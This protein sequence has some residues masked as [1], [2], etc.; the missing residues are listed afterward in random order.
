MISISLARVF[1]IFLGVF[2]ICT[3]ANTSAMDEGDPWR[4]TFRSTVTQES[5]RRG[6]VTN[7]NN[8]NH[9]ND[10][11]YALRRGSIVVD[12]AYAAASAYNHK[13]QEPTTGGKPR[14]DEESILIPKKPLFLSALSDSESHLKRL[15][16]AN[17]CLSVTEIIGS[18]VLSNVFL[19]ASFVGTILAG[20][21]S[22]FYDPKVGSI[23]LFISG[24]C[25][26]VGTLLKQVYDTKMNVMSE[27]REKSFASMA[28]QAAA[29]I[30]DLQ[31]GH[32]RTKAKLRQEKE[33]K[34]E[35]LKALKDAYAELQGLKSGI[36]S[37][38][39]GLLLHHSPS[40]RGATPDVH[41]RE[42]PKRQE[43]ESLVQS[44]SDSQK[45][46]EKPKSKRTK[47]KSKLTIAANSS[48]NSPSSS[49][50]SSDADVDAAVAPRK[51]TVGADA[52][53][54]V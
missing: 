37:P 19:G 34:I 42:K 39:A 43:K 4:D 8:R 48:A 6:I 30:G 50:E 46:V 47:K 17:S 52:S 26:A 32:E 22:Q 25:S 54:R 12:A 33:R 38:V 36:Q 11:N 16:S 24:G 13:I 27:M 35:E 28:T 23:V 7:P 49:D 10:N 41:Q 45:L 40:A 14:N 2:L 15:E 9:N 20:G 5:Q 29:E 18:R 21:L 51:T 1:N 3:V 53:D 31:A 44:D